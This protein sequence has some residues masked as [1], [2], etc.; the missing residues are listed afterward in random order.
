MGLERM[1]PQLHARPAWVGESPGRA[2]QL[3]HHL[4]S[5]PRLRAELCSVESSDL[6]H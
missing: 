1:V 3:G 2:A 5:A 6:F 4:T